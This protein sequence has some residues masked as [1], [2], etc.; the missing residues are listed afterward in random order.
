MGF[1]HHTSQ[2]CMRRGVLPFALLEA[3]MVAVVVA[4]LVG[5]VATSYAEYRIGYNLYDFAK[6]K[7]VAV[8]AKVK[9]VY[10][11]VAGLF[12]KKPAAP[13]AK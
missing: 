2:P 3:T 5:A 12:G 9:A 4:V 7:V 6:D 11:K 13:V 1:D 10:A 8:V